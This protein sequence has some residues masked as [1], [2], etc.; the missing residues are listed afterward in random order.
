VPAELCLYRLLAVATL[1]DLCGGIGER[2]HHLRRCEPA[3]LAAVGAGRTGRLCLRQFREIGTAVQLGDDRDRLV[4]CFHQD[5]AGLVLLDWNTELAVVELP[6]HVVAYRVGGREIL[7]GGTR[8]H[9]ALLLVEQGGDGR[10]AVEALADAFLAHQFQVD[11]FIEDGLFI[12]TLGTRRSGAPLRGV[13]IEHGLREHRAVYGGHH[14][15][16]QRGAAATGGIAKAVA[17]CLQLVAALQG[18]QGQGN[19]QG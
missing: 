10:P 5:V 11:Q 17:R 13:G 9:G 8:Q 15:A 19:Y 4:L 18:E 7:D 16:G 1:V 3:Q 14:R 2:L 12:S 6:Y